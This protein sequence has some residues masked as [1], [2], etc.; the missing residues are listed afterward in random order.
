MQTVLYETSVTPCAVINVGLVD[1][2]FG[3]GTMRSYMR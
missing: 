3:V 2:T 1:L